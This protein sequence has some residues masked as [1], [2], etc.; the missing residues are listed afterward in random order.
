MKKL[1]KDLFMTVKPQWW[2]KSVE[3]T[4][5][6][7]RM[8]SGNWFMPLDGNPEVQGDLRIRNDTN[9]FLLIEFKRDFSKKCIDQEK[10]K[11]KM[12][13]GVDTFQLTLNKLGKY[14]DFHKIVYGTCVENEKLYITSSRYFPFL[15]VVEGKP[16]TMAVKNMMEHAVPKEVFDLYIL[17]FAYCKK[18]GDG[19]SSSGGKGVIDYKDL[20]TLFGGE[21]SCV[22]ILNDGE[23]T[24]LPL[25]D[26]IRIKWG[27]LPQTKLDVKELLYSLKSEHQ[28]LKKANTL[29]HNY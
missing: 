27:L 28:K 21:K 15:Q 10:S 12:S 2:E 6:F 5:I 17:L 19:S 1:D 13:N 24:V 22:A 11:Y 18:F 20:K 8:N 26:F 3:Y 23:T 14:S 16:K 29:D 7:D 4:Y 9:L 25:I